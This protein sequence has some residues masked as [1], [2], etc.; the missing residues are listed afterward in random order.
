[1]PDTAFMQRDGDCTVGP[2][3]TQ[4][5]VRTGFVRPEKG[6]PITITKA[7]GLGAP[8]IGQDVVNIQYGLDQTAP[9]DG[10][11]STPLVIDGKCGPKTNKAIRDFQMKQFGFSG[12][13]GR[14]DPGRQTIQRLNEVRNDNISPDMPLS[15]LDPTAKGLFDGMMQHIPHTK[16]CIMA[17]MAK[18]D[19]AIPSADSP[20]GLIG[21]SRAERMALINK[22]FKVDDNSAFSSKGQILGKINDIYRNMLAVLNKPDN[23][24]TLD[25]DNSGVTIS[26]VAFARLGGFFDKRDLSGRIVFRS[27][28][29]F[30]T[31]IPDF[32]AFIFIHELRHF[33]EQEQRGGHFGKGWVTDPGML[34]LTPFERLG[35]CDTYAGF[36][37]EA[38]NGEM[39]RPVYIKS[40]VFR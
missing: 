15:F 36:A 31:G 2:K 9:I 28:V 11:P 21:P 22:H 6:K 32:A 10:G 5:S 39:E 26:T 29:L 4:G 37:L 19:L 40:S 30:A 12:V 24:F 18:I 23:F 14:I 16:N 35:N 34:K 20:A 7:V 27:G 13:D 1:M 3:E 33:I 38:K 17:A 25:T 8:N